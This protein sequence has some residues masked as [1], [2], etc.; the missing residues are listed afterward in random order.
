MAELD[1]ATLARPRS[2]LDVLPTRSVV[3]ANFSPDH[4]V[5]HR[6]SC[7][8][9]GLRATDAAGEKRDAAYFRLKEVAIPA[10]GS[11]RFASPPL[12]RRSPLHRDFSR[13]TGPG[14]L[15]FGDEAG[16][17][18]WLDESAAQFKMLEGRYGDP[19]DPDNDECPLW[20]TGEHNAM[21]KITIQK[22]HMLSWFVAAQ[23]PRNPVAPRPEFRF[24]LRRL[25][26]RYALAVIHGDGGGVIPAAPR[27]ADTNP[28]WPLFSGSVPGKALG[29]LFLGRDEAA[30]V[31]RAHGQEF[32]ALTGL[33]SASAFAYG[34]AGRSGALYKWQELPYFDGHDNTW[35]VWREARGHW[36]RNRVVQMSSTAVNESLDYIFEWLKTGRKRIRGL[37]HTPDAHAPIQWQ[38]CFRYESDISGY[39]V[40]VSD[41]MKDV[42]CEELARLAKEIED[43]RLERQAL[44][45]REW[46][47]LPLITPSWRLQDGEAS[48]VSYDGG[49]HSGILLVSEMGTLVA[50]ALT[51]DALAVQDFHFEENP[52][53]RDPPDADT[54]SQGDDTAICATRPIN[55]TIWAQTWRDNGFDCE[56][57]RGDGFL[58]AHRAQDGS[59]Y[60]I[61]ARVNQNT[62]SPEDPVISRHGRALMAEQLIAR[63]KYGWHLGP[64]ELREA[65]WACL[66]KLEFI[67]LAQ[68]DYGVRSLEELVDRYLTDPKLIEARKVALATSTGE[69]W[70]QTQLR[71]AEHSP[72]GP[73]IIEHFGAL[74]QRGIDTA[75]RDLITAVRA[76]PWVWRRT[77]AVT[78]YSAIQY[79][80]GLQWLIDLRKELGLRA[81]PQDV[82]VKVEEDAPE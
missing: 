54:V 62:G 33:P 4:W 78:G 10:P 59:V 26:R 46:E 61:Y 18:A 3:A 19:T 53:P 13:L 14:D 81:D 9:P 23:G 68:K 65:T 37:W 64:A 39:D 76:K 38:R 20:W 56:L 73:Y 8:P 40:S 45:W 58:G 16:A 70:I 48:L 24:A 29:G 34:L 44:R 36:Q 47:R 75:N 60:P 2:L 63:T 25:L 31:M 69:S 17:D 27:P 42:I 82:K 6:M 35:H 49:W 28:G 22:G 32:C 12:M 50:R 55:P 57:A 72:T 11:W 41:A 71:A 5:F 79:G 74:A 21:K 51:E 80:D 52:Q 7:Q 77:R 66:S 30:D 67:R 1:N 43:V 15:Y